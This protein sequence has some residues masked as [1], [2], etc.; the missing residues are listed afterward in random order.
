MKQK[1]LVTT[2]SRSEYGILLPLLKELKKN[3]K[4]DLILVVTG[5]HLSKKHGYTI[6]EIKKDG[7]R[8]NATLK[9]TPNCL[10]NLHL[11]KAIGKGVIQFAEIFSKFK[12]D[13]NFIM[14]DRDEM[15]SSAIAASH[16]N[17]LNAHLAGGDVS[18]GLDEY[19]R[20]A[21]TKFSNIHFTN[22][23]QSKN[24][25]I[26][27]GE[28]PKFVFNTGS[29]AIDNFKNIATSKCMLEKKLNLKFIGN[30]IILIQHPVTTQPNEV[31]NQISN[32][33]KSLVKLK[34]STIVIA[35]NSDMKSDIIVNQLRKFSK[36]YDFINFYTNFERNDFL[37]LLQ[38][39]G[40]LLGNSSSG[41]AEASCFS[42]PVINIGIRQKGRERGKKIIELKE[43]DHKIIEKSILSALKQ[44]N[45]HKILKNSAY[46]DGKS[47]QRIAKILEKPFP[48]TLIQKH[49]LY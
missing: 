31:K 23:K 17:I 18:G 44:P 39:C 13:I 32:T 25:L 9:I 40:V 28:D 47:S 14:G 38:N 27:M 46:G 21:I 34:K 20:H 3:P 6:N 4:I 24:R 2:G 12:P 16:M 43:F 15:L 19:N 1:I 36:K 29:P 45:L 49:I 7:F 30:E 42:I 26:K 22:T 37:G 8:I 33:L 35:P 11:T 10:D 5:T 41:I 48:K